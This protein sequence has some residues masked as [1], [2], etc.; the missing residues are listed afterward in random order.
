MTTEA[1]RA[2]DATRRKGGPRA[3][4]SANRNGARTKARD[5]HVLR[6]VG[7][8]GEG[9][10]R[11]DGTHVYNLL[12]VGARSLHHP[13]GRALTFDDIAGFLWECHEA[14]PEAVMVGFFLGY[15]FAQW[16]RWL[17][18]D[19]ARALLTEAGRA[20]RQR[21]GSHGNPIPFPVRWG[22]WEFDVLPN[23]RRFKLRPTHVMAGRCVACGAH[24]DG[25]A[26]AKNEHSWLYVCD[27]GSFFQSK[28]T[29]AVNPEKWPEPVVTADEY[30]RLQEGK[31]ARSGPAVPEGT[32]VDPVT[33]AYNTLENDALAR[34]MDR[35]N[36][37]LV[38]MGLRLTR[39][40]W[41]G[42]GQAAQAWLKATAPEHTGDNWRGLTGLHLEPYEAAM[43]S[44]FGGWFEIMAHGPVPG[45]TWN[46]DINSAYPH[47]I[48][49][50][51][52]LLPG[53]GVWHW[54]DGRLPRTKG[55]YRL[56][57]ATVRGSDP[58]IGA[59]LHRTT[60][61]RV[62]RPHGTAGWYWHHEL[63]AARR[64][65]L[66]DKVTYHEWWEYRGSCSCAPPFRAI[67]GLYRQR[68]D[69]TV[70]KNSPH[71]RALRLVYNSAYGKMAQS[72][73]QPMFSNPVYASLITAGCR[74]MILDAIATHPEGTGAVLMVATDGVYFTSRHPG[75]HV[76][77]TTLGAWDESELHDLSLFKP[78]VYWH[79]GT[80]RA[81]I[82][83]RGVNEAALGK[84]ISRLDA[85]W[86]RRQASCMSLDGRPVLPPGAREPEW[87][88]STTIAVPFSVLSPRQALQRNRWELCGAIDTEGTAVQSAMPLGKRMPVE[89]KRA[90]GSFYRTRPWGPAGPSTPYDKRFGIELREA[91]WA[92][93]K[94]MPEGDWQVVWADLMAEAG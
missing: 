21:T 68:I 5:E 55:R 34:M 1:R 54:G 80:R 17:P 71:G 30:R 73:G 44:Y 74:T 65:G 25:D 46:Y 59:M 89:P 22:P 72:V 43:A 86:S 45:S 16:L 75:L 67:A 70:G 94:L 15:D 87:W 39:T 10:T 57:R 93:E 24:C 3:R 83:S 19:R 11:P 76:D 4:S 18:E 62:L 82:K 27:T 36:V 40:Q 85:Q 81:I 28:F 37:G 63:R 77:A 14:D 79:K 92:V 58:F 8:D 88:P 26:K 64:A 61:G 51:P 90:P 84:V 49:G 69:P 78:G 7:V 9:V 52:C 32:P 33:I 2:Y 47:I 20:T 31:A 38:A 12:S 66:I 53:H 29:T 56:V 6:F 50:L 42:P 41:H 60:K 35:Y 48:A 13:D 23:M 91:G